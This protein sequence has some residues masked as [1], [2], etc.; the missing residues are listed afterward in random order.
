[1][2]KSWTQIKNET[3]SWE[4]QAKAHAL[5]MQDL[6]EIET[7]ELRKFLKVSQAEIAK[8]MTQPAVSKIERRPNVLLGTIYN[9]IQ[10]LGGQLEIY[11][12]A[13]KHAVRLKHLLE[14]P[15][16]SRPKAA[17]RAHLNSK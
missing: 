8:K 16:K 1:M 5:A 11:A 14:A 9:Y 6:R 17:L 12:V 13:G 7:G 2:R 3:M 15:K 10:A 4:A